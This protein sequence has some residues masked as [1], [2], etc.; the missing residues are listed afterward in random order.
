M[1]SLASPGVAPITLAP[2]MTAIAE[3]VR[4]LMQNQRLL[5]HRNHGGVICQLDLA[6]NGSF[7]CKRPPGFGHRLWRQAPMSRWLGWEGFAV[8]NPEHHLGTGIGTLDR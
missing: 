6:F 7:R 1:V 3:R 8:A 5:L 2:V 4:R